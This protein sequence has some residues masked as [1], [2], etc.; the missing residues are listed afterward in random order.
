MKKIKF[1]VSGA[2]QIE[3]SWTTSQ[4]NEKALPKIPLW[5]SI[6]DSILSIVNSIKNLF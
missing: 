5:L 1:K 2:V 3:Y 6:V 4:K